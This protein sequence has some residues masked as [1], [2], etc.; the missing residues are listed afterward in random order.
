MI[1]GAVPEQVQISLQDTIWRNLPDDLPKLPVPGYRIQRPF[2]YQGIR[3]IQVDVYPWRLTDTG[4]MQYLE[5]GTVHIHYSDQESTEQLPRKVALEDSVQYLILVAP[6]LLSAA[7]DLAELHSNDVTPAKQLHTAVVNV[8]TLATSVREFVL[9]KLEQ[10]PELNYLLLMGDEE[11]IPP[12][13]QLFGA[14]VEHPSDDYYSSPVS[15]AG[16]TALPQVS[17][18]RIPLHDLS[19]V[20]AYVMKVRQYTLNPRP[21]PWR[22]RLALVADDENK[23]SGILYLELK[24]TSYSDTLYRR[25]RN[26]L[27]VVPLYGTEYTHQPGMGWLIQPELTNDVINTLNE[28][29][30]MINYIGHGSPTTLADEQILD[31]DRDLGQIQDLNHAI[32]VVGTCKFGWYDGKDAMSEALLAKEAGAIGLITTTRDISATSNFLFLDKLFDAVAGYIYTENQYRLG[33]LLRYVKNNSYYEALFHI[34]GDPAL[35][36]PFPQTHVMIDTLNSSLQM[37]ILAP[38]NVQLLPQY[39]NQSAYLRV[40]GEE[41]LVTRG[42]PRDMP[43]DSLIYSLPGPVIYDGGIW[44]NAQFIIPLDVPP[45]FARIQVW[46]DPIGQLTVEPYHCDFLKDIPLIAGDDMVEDDIPPEITLLQG[47]AILSSPAVIYA[48]FELTVQI[49]D[50]TGV[51]LMGNP[52]HEFRYWIDEL[53]VGD[54]LASSYSYETLALG[55]ASLDLTSLVTGEITLHIEV[56]DNANNPAQEHWTLILSQEKGNTVSKLVNYPNPFEQDTYFTFHLSGLAAVK[57]RVFTLEG[58]EIATLKSAGPLP[59]G[60]NTLYWNGRDD[61]GR[62]PANGTYVYYLEA[63]FDNGDSVESSGKLVILQ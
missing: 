20:Q 12:L 4:R 56:W 17:T 33:D 7:Q 18:G 26:D 29:V 15:E 37:Q 42:F 58:I 47:N 48:P 22:R 16:Y 46:T 63:R 51:N 10:H 54:E 44:G 14:G 21:G 27:E 61:Q 23:S 35:T 13:Y 1:P 41:R 59:A 34:F 52:G 9:A 2:L 39:A 45:G 40:S 49:F 24:H 28:G 11:A 43:T 36:L 60:Y 19:E 32:W 38:A 6:D 53:G 31:M 57:I 50:D 8:D 62:Q 3:Q 25:F 30:A 55:N 5:S